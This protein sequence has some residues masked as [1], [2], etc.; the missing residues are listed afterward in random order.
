MNFKAKNILKSN[1]YRT[2]Q[3]NVFDIM[4]QSVF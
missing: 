4:M 1:T 3:H 2:P